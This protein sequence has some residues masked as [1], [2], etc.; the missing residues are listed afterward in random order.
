MRTP[1]ASRAKRDLSEAQFRAKMQAEGW[2]PHGVFGYWQ[3]ESGLS[4]SRWNVEGLPR[5][6]QL[7]YFHAKLAQHLQWKA[8]R[9]AEAAAR[10]EGT[11]P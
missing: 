11:K 3:H 4:I 8:A 2:V 5:R 10:K 7:V 1:K 6:R 9:K